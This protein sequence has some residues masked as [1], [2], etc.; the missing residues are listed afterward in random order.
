MIG[1]QLQLENYELIEK[2]IRGELVLGNK[3]VYTMT[4]RPLCQVNNIKS[5]DGFV[6]VPFSHCF[7]EGAYHRK[8]VEF[9]RAKALCEKTMQ[10]QECEC[11]QLRTRNRSKSTDTCGSNGNYICNYSI[12][13][14][15]SECR[16]R[17]KKKKSKSWSCYSR[18]KCKKNCDDI[19]KLTVAC[20]NCGHN[21]KGSRS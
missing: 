13:D 10:L 5:N 14:C 11:K 12:R 17:C 15:Q 8:L 1:N 20:E 4:G 18:N 7:K 21:S 9:I 16:D 2:T 3:A 19:Y 6:L